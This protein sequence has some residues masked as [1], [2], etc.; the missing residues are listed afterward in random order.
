MAAGYCSNAEKTE[1]PTTEFVVAGETP[2]VSMG[3]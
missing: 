1:E 3:S 2:G